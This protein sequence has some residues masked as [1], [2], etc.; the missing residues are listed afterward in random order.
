MQTSV[1]SRKLA[2]GACRR[3]AGTVL[4][5]GVLAVVGALLIGSTQAQTFTVLHTFKPFEGFYG[6]SNGHHD[7]SV[8]RDLPA[9]W[10]LSCPVDRENDPTTAGEQCPR[11]GNSSIGYTFNKI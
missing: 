4:W 5:L 10:I 8:I 1:Q 3:A 6:E 2:L 7:P 9:G 11:G